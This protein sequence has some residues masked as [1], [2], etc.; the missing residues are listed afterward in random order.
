MLVAYLADRVA[1]QF[2]ESAQVAH[3]FA[4]HFYK[5]LAIADRVTDRTAESA[6]V[7]HQFAKHF[8]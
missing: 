2:A 3:Q 6:R 5:L 7:A 8:T 1:D 4:E